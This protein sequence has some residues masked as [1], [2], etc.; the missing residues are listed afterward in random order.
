MDVARD[1]AADAA[2]DAAVNRAAALF[3]GGCN[4]AESVLEALTSCWG[5]APVRAVATALGGGMAG[6]GY[7]C[8]A[9]V[10]GLLAVGH[11]RGPLDAAD[12]EGRRAAT[13]E[14]RE[15]LAWFAGRSPSVMCRDITGCDLRTSAGSA[16]MRAEDIKT[17]RCLPLVRDV[18]R[19]LARGGA[20]G[21]RV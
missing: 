21:G 3:D 9:L 10:G 7:V 18:V 14:A 12:R 5:L 4:C 8:G 17:K 15:L 19:H 2:A 20:G 13:A 16:R 6:S 1:A 11:R